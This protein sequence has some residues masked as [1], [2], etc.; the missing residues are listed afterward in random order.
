MGGFARD[1]PK[2]ENGFISVRIVSSRSERRHIRR[3]IPIFSDGSCGRPM[4]P[5]RFRA[6]SAARRNAGAVM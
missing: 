4:W 3:K 5:G 6:R 1:A 2:P